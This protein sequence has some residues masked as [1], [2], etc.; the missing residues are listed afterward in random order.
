[1]QTNTTATSRTN[2]KAKNSSTTRATRPT[3]T[4]SPAAP[5]TLDHQEQADDQT[6]PQHPR[7]YVAL[8]ECFGISGTPYNGRALSDANMVVEFDAPH[9]VPSGLFMPEDN[10][11]V[12]GPGVPTRVTLPDALRWFRMTHMVSSGGDYANGFDGFLKR[13]EQAMRRQS[14]SKE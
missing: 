7:E 12:L 8:K 2:R 4:T 3:S 6:R 14:A 13:V 9:G 5:D 11:F 1:M 10:I